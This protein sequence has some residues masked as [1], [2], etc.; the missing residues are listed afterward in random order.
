[1]IPG[2]PVPLHRL[3]IKVRSNVGECCDSV[4]VPVPLAYY[5]NS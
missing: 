1:V 5:G 3:T 2:T 4:A